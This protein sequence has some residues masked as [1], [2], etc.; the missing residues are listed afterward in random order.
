MPTPAAVFLSYTSADREAAERLCAG[1]RA[2]GVEVWFDRNDLVGGDAW[3]QKIRKQIAECALFLPIISANTETRLEGYFRREWKQAALRT[4]DMAEEK[5]FLLPVVIDD[6]GDAEARVPATFRGVQWTRLRQGEP[7]PAFTAQVQRLLGQPSPAAKVAEPKVA[8]PGV[9]E[10]RVAYTAAVPPKRADTGRKRRPSLMVAA[11]GALVVAAAAYWVVRPG[12]PAEPPRLAVFGF[13]AGSEDQRRAQIAETAT[14]EVFDLLSGQQVMLASRTQTVGVASDQQFARAESLGARFLLSGDIKPEIGKADSIRVAIRLEDAGTRST[15]WEES[16]AA[17][18]T[19]PQS[20]ALQSA[21]RAA[22]AALCLLRHYPVLAKSAADKDLLSPL[23]IYCG[24]WRSGGTPESSR[25]LQRLAELAPDDG[26]IQANLAYNLLDRALVAANGG[27]DPLLLG[28]AEQIFRRAERL[29]PE[30]FN[31]AFARF[32]FAALKSAPLAELDGILRS[33]LQRGMP[34][35][36]E[37][38]GYQVVNGYL[39]RLLLN[40]GRPQDALPFARIAT[41]TDPISVARRFTYAMALA[42]ANKV[43]AAEAFEQFY[44]RWSTPW[45]D[46]ILMG[47][48]IIQGAGDARALLANPPKSLQSPALEC[49]RGFNDA[50]Q[51]AGARERANG[52]ALVKSCL[53][54]GT[55]SEQSALPLLVRLGDLD[56]AFALAE[57]P[58]LSPAAIFNGLNLLG[59]H[60]VFFD[61]IVGPMRADPRFLPLMEKLGLMDYWRATR[62][63][64]DVCLAET[65]PFCAALKDTAA[66]G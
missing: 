60:G 53:A 43:G 19:D 17:E 15:L 26:D 20:V 22:D 42:D 51:A 37:I 23:S 44:L 38:D 64:P 32:R 5:A 10:P 6:T 54:S 36:W 27:L 34:Q 61:R 25:A 28:Q 58:A 59:S 47:R 31:V 13:N 16:F 62:S 3:D 40:A 1:L 30:N 57:T 14:T 56:A 63:R 2:G 11:L 4:H 55:I 9:A 35:P 12:A 46:E 50:L 41:E 52:V 39:A 48:A 29:A 33:A 66:K 45:K 49:W 24:G 21:A 65:A 18:V 8:E 7:T